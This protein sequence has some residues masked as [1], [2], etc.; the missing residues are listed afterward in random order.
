[1][2]YK[3]YENQTIRIFK[4]RKNINKLSITKGNKLSQ[5]NEI[6]ID[7]HFGEGNNYKL[8]SNLNIENKNFKVI[9]Y[10]AAPDYTYVIQKLSDVV[11]NPKNF[12]IGFV[13]EED[14]RNLKN[15]SYSYVFILN[16]ISADKLKNIVSKNST[17]T[18]FH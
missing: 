15:K 16:G 7:G 2:D 6:I 9:G 14:F 11:P 3:L 10:G 18:E 17:V 12:G 5:G 1:M 8:L 4:D 13:N